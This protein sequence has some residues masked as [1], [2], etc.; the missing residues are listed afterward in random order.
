M[1]DDDLVLV[2]MPVAMLLTPVANAIAVACTTCHQPVW[3][4]P[5]S[6]QVMNR[7]RVICAECARTEVAKAKRRG[8]PIE[9]GGPLPG[10]REEVEREL[11]REGE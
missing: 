6:F 11:D 10:Q 2:C 7:A 5:S 9:F 8:E 1:S 4:A 3:L